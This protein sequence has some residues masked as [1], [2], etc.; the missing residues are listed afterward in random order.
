MPDFPSTTSASDVWTLKDVEEAKL[1]SNFPLITPL[2]TPSVEYLIVAGGGGGSDDV[3][4]G[5]GAGGL[6]SGTVSVTAGLYNIV[7]GNGGIRGTTTFSSS[8]TAAENG[9]NT[10][11][12]GLTAVGGGRGAARRD[13]SFVGVTANAGG[14]GGGG[15][16]PATAGASGTAGQGN[17]GA[18]GVSTTSGGGGGGAGG[19]GS[20]VTG[21]VG[22]ASSITGTSTTYAVGGAGGLNP[23][24][25]GARNSAYGSGGGGGGNSPINSSTAGQN[26][27]AIIAY[28][29]TF[30]LATAT[31]G[32]PSYSGVSRSGYHV[33]TFT[34]SGSITF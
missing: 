3:A 12:F 31:T 2:V 9:G 11:A 16:Y 1:G 32:S 20:G 24:P 33:Y 30:P 8:G 34:G 17:A 18:S 13:G 10:T 4:G 21:G 19:A 27:V 5:G 14:S 22:S 25:G 15:A 28:S 23:G 29:S 7:I 6:L 26:G